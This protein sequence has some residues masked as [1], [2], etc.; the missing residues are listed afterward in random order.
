MYRFVAY[1]KN[2][3]FFFLIFA[4]IPALHGFYIV[5]RLRI[6]QR[7]SACL[8]VCWLVLYHK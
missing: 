7:Y 8:S 1:F 2:L 6:V 3:F 4:I 5:P